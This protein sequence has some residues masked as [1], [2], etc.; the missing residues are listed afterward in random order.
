MS[1]PTTKSKGQTESRKGG[2]GGGGVYLIDFGEMHDVWTVQDSQRQTDHLQILAARRGTDVT[3]L[4]ADII[5]NRLLKPGHKEMRSLFHDL[6]L[7]SRQTV[8]DDCP[9]PALDI[10]NRPAGPVSPDTTQ[11]TGEERGEYAWPTARA[12]AAGMARR[13]PSPRIRSITVEKKSSSGGA[14]KVAK[15]FGQLGGFEIFFCGGG[16]KMGLRLLR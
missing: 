16:G 1:D 10:V 4:R 14:C 13:E 2:L 3:R 8:K 9:C 12:I 15:S 11:C 7:D 5:D 6:L